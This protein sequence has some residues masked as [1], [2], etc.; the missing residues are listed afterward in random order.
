MGAPVVDLQLAVDEEAGAIVARD[1]EA[2]LAG[3]GGREPARPTDRIVGRSD[4]WIGALIAAICEIDGRVD[5]GEHGPTLEA[6]VVVIFPDQSMTFSVGCL[7]EFRRDWHGGE[8]VDMGT[9]GVLNADP[10]SHEGGQ[11]ILGTDCLPWLDL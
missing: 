7:D 5:T 2:V 8:R 3:L 1:G 4:P 11:S 10:V 9:L 6:R